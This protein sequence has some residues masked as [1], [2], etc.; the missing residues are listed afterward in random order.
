MAALALLGTCGANCHAAGA[1]AGAAAAAAAGAAAGA[2][3]GAAAGAG[4]GA[5]SDNYSQKCPLV[6]RFQP[7]SMLSRRAVQLLLRRAAFPRPQAA[8]FA[9]AATVRTGKTASSSG[10][11]ALEA[12]VKK[13]QESATAKFDETVDV[14]G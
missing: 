9:A 6:S 3:A 1:A 4:A 11:L 7:I 8:A 2:G 12:A 14:A 5:G 13:V 10:G